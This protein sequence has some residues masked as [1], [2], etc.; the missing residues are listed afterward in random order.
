[1]LIFTPDDLTSA[2]PI[3]DDRPYANLV[4]VARSRQSYGESG[5]TALRRSWS[6]GALGTSIGEHL[7]SSVHALTGAHK[8]RGYH[9]QISK[10]GE[11][12]FRYTVSQ[13][14]LL[15][16][17]GRRAYPY[18]VTVQLGGSGGYITEGFAAI[19]FRWGRIG[20]P[21]YGY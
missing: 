17:D 14:W 19:G 3:V 2:E 9:N 6:A 1:M 20:S 16:A 12:T 15:A 7:Q 11:P 13:H 21:W 8:P 5:R 10:G 18:D 4:F